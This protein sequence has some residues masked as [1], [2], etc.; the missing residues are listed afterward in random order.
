MYE[1]LDAMLSRLKQESVL[2]IVGGG[3]TSMLALVGS[4][5]VMPCVSLVARVG[6]T[7][8]RGV[9]LANWVLQNMSRQSV[10]VPKSSLQVEHAKNIRMKLR[11]NFDFIGLSCW[12]SLKS[13][14]WKGFPIGLDHICVNCAVKWY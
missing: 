9:R 8:G 6:A 3:V 1:F 13:M 12:M 2:L 7:N 5:M 10:T 4:T 11:C 14:A